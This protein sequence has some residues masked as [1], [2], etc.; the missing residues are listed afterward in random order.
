MV[1][2]GTID[3]AA[4]DEIIPDMNQTVPE[5]RAAIAGMSQSLVVC[6]PPAQGSSSP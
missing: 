2:C 5:L 1:E 4:L 3:L 6:G